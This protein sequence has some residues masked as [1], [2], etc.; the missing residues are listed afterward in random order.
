MT[1]PEGLEEA[2]LGGEDTLHGF[3]DDGSKIVVVLLNDGCGGLNIVEWGY[4][5]GVL[6]SLGDAAAAGV[7]LGEGVKGAGWITHEGVVAGAV[8]TSLEFENLVA[9]PEGT[10]DAEGL[11]TGVGAAGGETDFI[12]AG[13]GADKLFGKE[14]GIF[15]DCKEGAAVL[16]SFDDGLD[17]AGVGVAEYHGAGTHEV[18]YVLVAADVPD[19][20]AAAPLDDEGMVRVEGDVAQGP[21]WEKL[22]AAFSKEKSFFAG[23]DGVI[24]ASGR[25]IES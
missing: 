2:G 21:L 12:G 8:E 18:V 7:R 11:E 5:D 6:E 25:L 23:C 22:R 14:N 17:D 1:S 16:N 19:T 20:G 24:T 10:G 9:S 13:H 15:I 4:E 3:D